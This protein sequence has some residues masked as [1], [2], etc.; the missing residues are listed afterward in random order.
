MAF[1]A[2]LIT[3]LNSG[4]QAAARGTTDAV[5]Q[6]VRAPADILGTVAQ[7]APFPLPPFPGTAGSF[8]PALPG[9]GSNG[10]G[11]GN[12]NGG[13]NG[14]GTQ[15]LS[16]SGHGASGSAIPKGQLIQSQGLAITA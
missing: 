6:V 5:M 9:F 8:F 15:S 13:S 12:G 1:P 7:A 2:Q 16:A 4:V 14:T 3:G 10:N 11:N